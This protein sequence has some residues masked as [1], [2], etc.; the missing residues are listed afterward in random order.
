MEL[1][2]CGS[3]RYPQKVILALSMLGY[4]TKCSVVIVCHHGYQYDVDYWK[5]KKWDKEFSVDIPFDC[6]KETT[7]EI[8]DYGNE[9]LYQKQIDTFNSMEVDEVFFSDLMKEKD[10]VL[11]NY[12]K[13][14]VSRTNNLNHINDMETLYHKKEGLGRILIDEEEGRLYSIMTRMKS[15]YRHGGFLSINGEKFKEVDLSNSQP[16]LLGLMVKRKQQ[17][18]EVEFKSLWL[19]NAVKG[20]F[21]EWLMDITGLIELRTDDII[22]KLEKTISKDKK[23]KKTTVRES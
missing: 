14:K 3:Q 2:G 6:E 11:C 7:C 12:S 4:I 9:W 19:E 23:S 10:D 5:F 13:D 15:D 21:Y 17:E 22:I 8:P 18:R 16:T 20:D 1:T